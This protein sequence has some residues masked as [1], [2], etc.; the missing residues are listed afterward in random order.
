ME[1]SNYQNSDAGIKFKSFSIESSFPRVGYFFE[2]LLEEAKPVVTEKHDI[3]YQ[4]DSILIEISG[5]FQSVRIP[6]Q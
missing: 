4:D 2:T 3:K 5:S 6:M 1:F